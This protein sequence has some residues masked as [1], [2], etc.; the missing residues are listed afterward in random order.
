MSLLDRIARSN[1][2]PQR[3]I[4]ALHLINKLEHEGQVIKSLSAF[5]RTRRD[6]KARETT[7]KKREVE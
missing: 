7:H 1:G 3:T 6:S 5:V 4:A 2:N